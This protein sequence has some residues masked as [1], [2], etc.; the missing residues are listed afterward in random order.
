MDRNRPAVPGPKDVYS[1]HA[2]PDCGLQVKHY[3]NDQAPVCCN[4]S[5]TVSGHDRAAALHRA[6][7]AIE[8]GHQEG[9]A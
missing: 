3:P 7:L 2:L 9:A 8:R 4:V 1:V 6:Y 5:V